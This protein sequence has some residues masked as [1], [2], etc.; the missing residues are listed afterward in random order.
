[1]ATCKPQRIEY[2]K[3]KQQDKRKQPEVYLR[4]HATKD[5]IYFLWENQ[6]ALLDPK[7]QQ[8][9][10]G[11]LKKREHKHRHRDRQAETTMKAKYTFDLQ[12]LELVDPDKEATNIWSF[13]LA[14]G[15]GKLL[16]KMRRLSCDK[17]KIEYRWNSNSQIKFV[18]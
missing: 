4:T 3:G 15:G 13:S 18:Q 8:E 11:I 17:P 12:N 9:V 7:L 2:K 1:M 16:K 5:F 6:S 14:G 10:N